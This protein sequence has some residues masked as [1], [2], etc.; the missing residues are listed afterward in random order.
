M[1]HIIAENSKDY[2][3]NK[4]QLCSYVYKCLERDLEGIF[5][6]M[7]I[8]SGFRRVLYFKKFSVLKISTTST[9]TV[10]NFFFKGKSMGFEVTQ[11]CLTPPLS[12][13]IRLNHIKLPTFDH[14]DL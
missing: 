8:I 7:E 3:I 12:F 14:F 13:P 1:R 6:P 5:C 4:H 2:F 9:W 10:S 11:F